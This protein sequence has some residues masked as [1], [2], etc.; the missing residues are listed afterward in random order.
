MFRSETKK[1][2]NF[3][4][5]RK[6]SYKK[7]VLC[8]KKRLVIFVGKILFQKQIRSFIFECGVKIR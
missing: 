6:I 1:N 5:L 2:R 4:L 3:F 7:I 8:F